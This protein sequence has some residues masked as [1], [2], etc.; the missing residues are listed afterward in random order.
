MSNRYRY[1]IINENLKK[2]KD[3]K[4]KILIIDDDKELS[5]LICD[6]LEDNG[7]EPSHV[8]SME[9]AYEFLADN[10][11]HLILLDINLPDGL[12][13]DLCRELRLKSQIP[14][15][16]VSARTS[17]D[18]KVNG[19]DIGA[20]DYMAKPYSLKEMMSRINSLIRRTYGVGRGKESIE[21]TLK[22]GEKLAIDK[23]AR[24]VKKNNIRVELSPKE[25]DLLIYMIDNKGKSLTKEQ[26]INSVWGPYSEVEQSTLTVHIRWLR[27]KFESNPS[28]P[29]FI[30]TVWGIGYMLDI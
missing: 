3:N 6:M 5:M 19:L 28:R 1:L 7:Y 27:E 24:S 18:D 20:D 29:E 11:P 9:E 10:T 12:G 4:M 22:S 2:Y 30:K 25:Y 13:F 8:G 26:L 17:E 15:I 16:F 23:N 21:I 14:I